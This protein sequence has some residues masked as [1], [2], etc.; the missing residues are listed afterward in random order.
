MELNE[1]LYQQ[2]V[3]I[4][5][6]EEKGLEAL[7]Q[8]LI[9]GTMHTAI[10][11]EADAVGVISCLQ[12]DDIVVSNHRCHGHFLAYGGLPESLFAELMGK[13]GGV[14]SGRGGSQHL[15]WHNF[16]SN[17]VQGGIIPM[18]CGMAL[19]EK[20]IGSGAI[21]VVFMGDGTLGEGVVYESL[22]MASLWGAPILFVLENN[23]IAQT[24]P[25]E[26]ALSGSM[27]TRFEAFGIPTHHLDSSDVLEI[28]ELTDTLV[29]EVRNEG[30]PRALII[31][32][33]RFGAHSKGD[34]TRSEL[35]MAALRAQR[36]PL[37]IHGA[38]LS[39]DVRYTI[40]LEAHKDINN[41]FQ[42]AMQAN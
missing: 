17:G 23:H 42:S 5:R 25:T 38:R 8:G 36:D 32:T 19:A 27:T 16:Y 4:R 39:A 34:D 28:K 21:T 26:L 41:A 18:A 35:D 29:S 3:K 9:F 13:E 11:Q 1:L 31:N 20:R 7:K 6:F 15:H 24:T 40:D 30:R 33:V 2:M 12:S 22:N 37:K 10:G 14:C